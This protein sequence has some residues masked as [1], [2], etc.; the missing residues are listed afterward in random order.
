MFTHTYPEPGARGG[1]VSACRRCA[2]AA[3]V[4]A[5]LSGCA[6]ADFL[7]QHTPF[8]QMTKAR[9]PEES[10]LLVIEGDIDVLYSDAAAR[11][12]GFVFLDIRGDRWTVERSLAVAPS[13]PGSDE[14]PPDTRWGSI[15]LQPGDYTLVEVH[16]RGDNHACQCPIQDGPRIEMRLG[17]PTYLGWF[18][19]RVRVSERGG[20]CWCRDNVG[21]PVRMTFAATTRNPEVLAWEDLVRKYPESAWAEPMRDRIA[22]LHAGPA[23]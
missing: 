9:P 18:R 16:L 21:R 20:E 11:D 5:V 19:L 17:A 2:A 6:A 15:D 13:V 23:P 10:A 12:V 22:E 4:G 14:G 7:R 3:A 8:P 1:M